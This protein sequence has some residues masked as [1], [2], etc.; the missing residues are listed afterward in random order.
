MNYRFFR[1]SID[2]GKMVMP[3]YVAMLLE[4]RNVQILGSFNDKGEICGYM[5][6]QSVPGLNDRVYVHYV[7]IAELYRG[8]GYADDLFFYVKR[9]FSKQGCNKIICVGIGGTLERNLAYRFMLKQGFAPYHTK[10]HFLIYGLDKME[11]SY[12]AKNS[13][14]LKKLGQLTRNRRQLEDKEFEEFEEKV[15]DAG[16]TGDLSQIDMD[17]GRFYVEKGE[18]K[19]FLQM[20]YIR[21]NVLYLPSTWLDSKV[22]EAKAMM[23]MAASCMQ[24]AEEKLDKNNTWIILQLF[25]NNGYNGVKNLFGQPVIDYRIDE[26]VKSI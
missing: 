5:V 17:F 7:E 4:N 11:E 23:A 13:E 20:E 10:G 14:A 19:A 9:H 18:V 15:R 2:E 25:R 24:L 1:L 12:L 3:P 16:Y 26:Y 22:D 6:L 8:K 21:E